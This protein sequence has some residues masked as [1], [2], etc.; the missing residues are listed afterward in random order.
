MIYVNDLDNLYHK[1]FYPGMV[2]TPTTGYVKAE[3][4]SQQV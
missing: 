3:N 1:L 2:T 4:C